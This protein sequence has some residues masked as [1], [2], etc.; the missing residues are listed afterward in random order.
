M[1]SFYVFIHMN[2]K[3][4]KPKIH[5]MK[6]KFKFLFKN[7][8]SEQ[9]WIEQKSILQR[10]IKRTHIIKTHLMRKNRRIKTYEPH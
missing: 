4:F 7:F 5:L 6:F 3:E 1:T 8:K 2:V 9:Q 10:T